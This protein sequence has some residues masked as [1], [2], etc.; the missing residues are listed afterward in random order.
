MEF[1]E[2]MEKGNQLR[3]EKKYEEALDAYQAALKADKRRPEA[4]NMKASTLGLLGQT[5]EAIECFEIAQSLDNNPASIHNAGLIYLEIGAYE[6]AAM[7]FSQA[8]ELEGD[9]PTRYI[10]LAKAEEKIGN[11]K[12]AINALENAR[13]NPSLLLAYHISKI[14]GK[15]AIED[16]FIFSEDD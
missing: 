7:A 13:Y 5:D 16:V 9:V 3:K 14:L 11:N 12:K 15:D 8:I 10:A 4:W 1:D 6:K 2:L